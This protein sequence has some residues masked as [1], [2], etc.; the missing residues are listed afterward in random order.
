MYNIE[1]IQAAN[2]TFLEMATDPTMKKEAEAMAAHYLKLQ[3][4]EDSFMERILPAQSI[5]P[6]QCD[7]DVNSP[8]YQVVIDKEFTDVAAV[9]TTF[10]GRSNYTLAETERYA[11]A[12]H[13]IESEEVSINEGELR[14]TRQPLQNI[15]RH[16]I[17]YEIRKKMDEMFIGMCNEAIAAS[18]LELDLSG[19]SEDRITPDIIYQLRNLIDDQ[20][21]Q[22]LE[23]A[24]LLMTKKQYNAI[25]TWIQANTLT[26]PGGM[27]GMAG[28]LTQDAWRDGYA[29]DK[30]QGLRIIVTAKSDLLPS[31]EVMVF[32]EP[33]YLGHHFTFNDDRFAID[34]KYDVLTWKGFRTFGASIGNINAVAK[35]KLKPS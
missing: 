30:L 23:A 1:Q 22:Y 33:E 15:I 20:S 3:V 13:K 16:K 32:T 26:T 7:R 27:P 35:I 10:R 28:G 31:N 12:F 6:M 4:Y 19:G 2:L 21:P 29:Y 25:N 34:H 8:N 5:S 18:G 14:G 9:T 11:V 24:T 17:A